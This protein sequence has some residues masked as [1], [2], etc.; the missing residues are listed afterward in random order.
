MTVRPLGSAV[1]EW[2]RDCYSRVVAGT[3]HARRTAG[4]VPQQDERL[5]DVMTQQALE[6]ER[7]SGRDRR[8]TPTPALGSYWLR[9]NRMSVRRESEVGA[10]YYVDRPGRTALSA[11]GLLAVLV[12]LDGMLT[13]YLIERGAFEANPV[14][15]FV[16]SLGVPVFLGVKYGA[17]VVALGVLLIHKNFKVVHPRLRVK[18]IIV[19][20]IGVYGLLV[21]YEMIAVIAAAA[22]LP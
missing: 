15:A 1:M 5:P 14:M 10:G 3:S 9:G 8:A 6:A 18:W 2:L 13:L 17:T 4:P 19:G 20:L 22:W 21:A 11:V 16:L 7:R 12:L